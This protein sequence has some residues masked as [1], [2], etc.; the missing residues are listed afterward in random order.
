MKGHLLMALLLLSALV[1]CVDK[2]AKSDPLPSTVPLQMSVNRLDFVMGEEVELTISVAGQDEE[3]TLNEDLSIDLSAKVG[4]NHVDRLL[5]DDFPERV[6]MKSGSRTMTVRIPIKKAGINTTYTVELSAFARGY[7][8]DG[9]MHLITISDYHYTTIKLKNN[10]DNTVKEG[11]SFVLVAEVNMPLME[12]QVVSISV[13]ESLA[14]RF[15]DLPETLTIP[16]GKT[17]AES[18]PITLVKST[19]TTADEDLVLHLSLPDGSRYPLLKSELVIHK[20]D[21]HRNMDTRLRDERWLY[22]DADQMYVSS[23]HE[24]EVKAWGQTNYRIM[25]EGDPHP[26]SGNVLPAGK[27]RFS[28]AYEFHHIGSCMVRKRSAMGD[29]ES[30]EYPLGFADQNTGAVETQGAVDN[31]K[32]AYVTDEGYL[33]MMTLKERAKS[34]NGGKVWDFGTSAFYSCK[35]MRGNANSPTWPSSNIR[36][37][38]GMRIETRARIRGTHNSG[39]LPGIWLQGNEQVGG[40]STW[41]MWPDFGEV[42]VMENNSRHGNIS[43]RYGVE[44]TLHFGGKTPGM[45]KGIYNPTR[46]ITELASGGATGKTVI[47]QFQIYWFEWIDEETVAVGVNGEETLRVTKDMVERNGSRWP[48]TTTVNDE[49]LYY[50][51]TMMFLHKAIPNYGETDMEMS[52]KAARNALKADHTLRIPRMEI[53]WVRFY[54]DDTYSDRGKPYRKDLILY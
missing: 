48:F 4:K 6:V 23:G 46:A 43:Y 36:I 18:A 51:L 15:A 12:D 16:K 29:Y 5:F 47:D 27:W 3:K 34:S 9:A 42:D 2:R 19:T 30:A 28:R 41:N 32:Y 25:K 7:K 54:T 22:E 26:N 11:Q 49:G 50:I 17:S 35:F 24:A 1:G 20:I 52:H 33:R 40:N 38:P 13:D 53:D 39:I 44:Q 31:T 37:Y 8:L 10:A 45:Q 14:D 21:L